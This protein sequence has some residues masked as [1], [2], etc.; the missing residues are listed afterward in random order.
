MFMSGGYGLPDFSRST[1]AVPMAQVNLWYVVQGSGAHA[2]CNF[3][4]EG[5]LRNI[6]PFAILFPA[7]LGK[8]TLKPENICGL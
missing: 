4:A 2:L 1:L 3:S 8:F 5:T 6:G 7:Q